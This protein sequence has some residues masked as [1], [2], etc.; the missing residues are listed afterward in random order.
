[1]K[2]FMAGSTRLRYFAASTQG[3]HGSTRLKHFMAQ[4]L[5]LR[6]QLPDLVPLRAWSGFHLI[7]V[8]VGSLDAVITDVIW[9]HGALA[10]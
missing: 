6:L 5:R 9:E 4:L 1:M 7:V 10:K 8:P 2:I 3:K